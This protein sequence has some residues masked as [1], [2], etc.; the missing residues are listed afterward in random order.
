MPVPL[1]IGDD[2]LEKHQDTLLFDGSTAELTL[3]NSTVNDI[4]YV[5]KK[6]PKLDEKL[7]S[8]SPEKRI[9]L[10]RSPIKIKGKTLQKYSR[11]S[12][13]NEA[14]YL[15]EVE[16]KGNQVFATPQLSTC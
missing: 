13:I 5:N 12:M 10:E 9:A 2:F 3:I 6:I 4:Q 15:T 11:R 14:Q 1:L 8:E 7:Q 16:D